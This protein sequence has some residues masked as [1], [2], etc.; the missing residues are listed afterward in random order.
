LAEPKDLIINNFQTG[1]AD[2]PHLGYGDIRNTD[3]YSFPGVA[4][5]NYTTQLS[6][7]AS[8]TPKWMVQS[9]TGTNYALGDAGYVYQYNGVWSVIAGNTKTSANGNGLAVWRDY[10]FVFRNSVVDLYGPLSGSPSWTTSWKILKAGDTHWHPAL[11]GQD[12]ILYY[13]DGRYVG[14]V[15]EKSGTTFDPAN[16]ATYTF[17]DAALTLP[18]QYRIKCFTELGVNLMI[19]TIVGSQSYGGVNI[20]DVF[21][22]DR[23][24]TS[25]RLPIRLNDTGVHQMATLANRIYMVA[26]L[27]PKIYVSDGY[28]IQ[29]LRTIPP[30]VVD[31]SANKFVNLY[32]GAIVTSK[33]RVMFGI[34]SGSIGLNPVDGL[35]VWSISSEG[36]LVYEY[37]IST[38][39]MNAT[40][41]LFIGSILS[42]G[43]DFFIGWRDNTS[44]GI[45][46]VTTARYGSYAAYLQ[47]S[48][49]EVGTPLV[50]RKFS[51]IEFVLAKP[52]ALGDGIRLKAR[53]DLNASFTTIGTSDFG[54][55]GAIQSYNFPFP[56]D[57]LTTIQVRAELTNNVQLKE[58][59]LR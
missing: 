36:K 14:S 6:F 37:Q 15:M 22:W 38:G 8:D 21:P 18:S 51:Q 10:L 56:M 48:L 33:G 53:P 11:V 1:T 7:T 54:T 45:D 41:N 27:Q 59:R 13:G 40:N 42:T 29:K 28:N 31:T 30:S 55:N 2:S 23:S 3:I 47:S 9:S 34:S 26:G 20:A 44:Y 52:L 24:S 46:S 12:D 50:K 19:G 16:A 5:P 35:G 17:T 43:S 49:Y 39:T 32:P 58:I 4:T 25:F 57:S